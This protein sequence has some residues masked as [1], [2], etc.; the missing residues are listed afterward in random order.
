MN[1]KHLTRVTLASSIAL[2]AFGCDSDDDSES[3]PNNEGA[4]AAGGEM[5]SE[6]GA[7]EEACGHA[8]NG[9]FSDTTA[10][11]TAEGAPDVAIEHTRVD[12]SL[13][14]VEGGKGGFVTFASAEAAEISFFLTNDV[15]MT[16][17]DASAAPLSPESSV[18]EI[19]ACGEIAVMHTFDLDVGT[20]TFFFGPTD[21][22]TLGFLF[23]E[24]GGHDHDHGH[25]HE[26]E[27]EGEGEHDHEGEG[28]HDHEGE[29]E[30]EDD[31]DGHDH[32]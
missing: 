26:G 21:A 4:G 13:V 31:H 15:P 17:V 12:I 16:V 32:E 7:L 19:A 27:G 11:D 9:P 3:S 1:L 24:A 5:G 30:G 22:T 8:Q 6:S 23:E 28:E 25:D 2:F 18:T 29:G 14:D 10:A 20:Y